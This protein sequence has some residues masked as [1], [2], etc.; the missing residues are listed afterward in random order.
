MRR[1]TGTIVGLVLA[2]GLAQPVTAQHDRLLAWADTWIAA[3][4]G[5]REPSVSTTVSD[6][7]GTSAYATR[8][9]QGSGLA[10]GGRRALTAASGSYWVYDPVHGIAAAS[11]YG[12]VHGDRIMYAVGASRRRPGPR[13]LAS[14]LQVRAASRLKHRRSGSNTPRLARRDQTYRTTSKHPLRSHRSA[15]R[16]RPLRA[17]RR[18]HLRRRPRHIDLA[19]GYRAVAVHLTARPCDRDSRRAARRRSPCRPARRR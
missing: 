19:R 16:Q 18:H 13:P 6:Y 3:A 12:D 9:R 17:R 5:P 4:D 7:F 11:E 2:F 1:L 8:R 10:A 15:M 14:R